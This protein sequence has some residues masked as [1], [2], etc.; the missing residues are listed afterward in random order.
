MNAYFLKVYSLIGVFVCLFLG[1]IAAQNNQEIYFKYCVAH[2][3]L[4]CFNPVPGAV[5]RLMVQ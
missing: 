3:Q 1:S 2:P 5:D 4:N